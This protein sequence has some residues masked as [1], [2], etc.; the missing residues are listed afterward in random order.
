[1]QSEYNRKSNNITNPAPNI[2]AAVMTAVQEEMT[3]MENRIISA[4]ARGSNE[5]ADD[6]TSHITDETADASKRKIG[7]IIFINTKRGEMYSFQT[8]RLS[9]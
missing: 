2:V 7:V 4:V 5:Q 6:A 3:V 9:P 8:I 1:M